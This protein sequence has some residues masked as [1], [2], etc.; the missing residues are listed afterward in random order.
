M[1]IGRK[2]ELQFLESQYLSSSAELIVLYGRR[3]IGKTETLTQF[4]KG[5]PAV[6]YACTETPDSEQLTRF[7]TKLLSTGMPASRYTSRFRNWDEAILSIRDLPEK[8]KKILV[9][10]EFPYMCK[11]NPAIPSILQNV[12]D[13]EL[14]K[15]NVMII[16]CGS[17]MSFMEKELLAEKNPLYGRATGIYRMDPMPFRDAQQFFP[18]WSLEDRISAFSIL[19]GIPYYLSRFDGKEDLKH[20][21]IHRILEKGSIL[22]SEV[23]FL[24]RQELRETNIY[25]AIIE[26][27][28]LGNTMLS[29]IH[30]KTGLDKSKISVYLKNLIELGIVE[31]EFSI[32]TSTAERA[33]SQR[34][35]YHL[36][37]PYFQFWYTFVYPNVSELETNDAEGVYRYMVE[38]K[39]HEFASHAFEKICTEWIRDM[40]REN[41][42]PFHFVRVGRWWD[43][44]NH[45]ENGRKWSTSEEIDILACSADQSRILL[46]E[47]KYRNEK[48]GTDVYRKLQSKFIVPPD[49]HLWYCLFSFSGFTEPMKDLAAKEG[50]LCFDRK[51]MERTLLEESCK[52]RNEGGGAGKLGI[53]DD[54]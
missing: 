17:S 14:A 3:R 1:F 23:D 37:D 54:E 49:T 25:N 20:N 31:R 43:K 12:W 28:A 34:G 30:D 48:T 41:R 13:H 47:C 11:G 42:L 15:E 6:F 39:L 26:A 2:N 51:D 38:P 29:L 33:K 19:G 4:I 7:S 35:L 22:Y 16:L 5:K 52:I 32:L 8:G 36:T 18:D 53:R 27:V 10:D 44:V 24:L 45:R 40:N 46:G 9:I 50:V 21:I